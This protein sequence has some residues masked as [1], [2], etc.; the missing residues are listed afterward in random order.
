MYAW[1]QVDVT[2]PDTRTKSYMRNTLATE[3][4]RR[5]HTRWC[6]RKGDPVHGLFLFLIV[7]FLL[8]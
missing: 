3:N 4:R 8:W 5:A 6:K 2:P 7:F 1:Q